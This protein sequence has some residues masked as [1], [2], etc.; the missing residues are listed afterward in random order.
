MCL[1]V[2]SI[3]DILNLTNL[4]LS[5]SDQ[6]RGSKFHYL[7]EAESS[8]ENKCFPRRLSHLHREKDETAPQGFLSAPHSNARGVSKLLRI[9]REN[10][11]VPLIG[12][13]VPLTLEFSLA[14]PV[15]ALPKH[16]HT[17]SFNLSP[18]NTHTPREHFCLS[19]SWR[20]NYT[21]E[22][23]WDDLKY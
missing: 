6:H 14:M 15:M 8:S 9:Q 21:S 22:S 10:R 7:C 16:R 13:A 12:W 19:K 4:T 11:V 20:W 18:P 1:K 5:E 2:S 3:Q 17:L 23:P